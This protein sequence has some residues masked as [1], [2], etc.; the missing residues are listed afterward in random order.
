MTDANPWDE[1]LDFWFGATDAEGGFDAS[2]NALWWGKAD[3]TDAAIRER[4]LARIE[5]ASDESLAWPDLP[6]ARLGRV[7]LI[8]QMR[9]NAFRDTPAMYT[10][11]AAARRLVLEGLDAGVDEALHPIMRTFFYLPLE[12][13]EELAHQERCVALFRSLA[14]VV[15]EAHR[16]TYANFVTYAVDHHAIVARFG[17]FPHRNAILG[18]ESTPDEVAFLE[19]PGSSF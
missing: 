19:T 15:G 9:R 2:K 14:E 13:S 6:H 1:I 18:R 8:D 12:H 17:R 10:A 5:A 3:A 4:F 16:D 7:I 11:D